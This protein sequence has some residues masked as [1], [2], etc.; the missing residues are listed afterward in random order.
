[1]DFN[2]SGEKLAVAGNDALIRIYN[3]EEKEFDQI[4]RSTG[5]NNPDH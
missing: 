3:E 2:C 4:L 5:K 1:M